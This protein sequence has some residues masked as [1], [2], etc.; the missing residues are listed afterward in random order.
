MPKSE[1]MQIGKYTVF[2]HDYDGD[3]FVIVDYTAPM[4]RGEYPGWKVQEKD[5]EAMMS[6]FITAKA[7]KLRENEAFLNAR[8]KA[9]CNA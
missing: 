4:V 9:L 2:H 5:L 6:A 8:Q 7:E 3:W 1:I